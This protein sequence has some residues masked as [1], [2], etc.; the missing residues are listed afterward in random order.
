MG[1][2]GWAWTGREGKLQMCFP[3][4]CYHFPFLFFLVVGVGQGKRYYFVNKFSFPSSR[5]FLGS[6]QIAVLDLTFI[7]MLYTVLFSLY[8][9]IK[10]EESP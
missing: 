8:F 10:G 6:V 4:T 9:R 1:W 2:L 7:T 3:N 5:C